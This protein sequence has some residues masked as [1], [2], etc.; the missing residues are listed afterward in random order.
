MRRVVA[1]ALALGTCGAVASHAQSRRLLTVDDLFNLRE[2]RDPQRSPDGQWVAYTVTRAIRD[3]DKNDTDVWMVSWDGTQ[4]I[5]VTST[6]E[7]ESRPRWSPDGKYLSFV[8]S[9]QG[10]KHAQVW[11]LNRAG[12]EAVKL[13]DVKGGVSDYAWSPDSGRLVLVVEDPDPA[14]PPEDKEPAKADP[15]KTPKPIVIDRY[16]FKADVDGYLRGERSH[17]YL[18]D[19]ASK[20]ADALTPGAF[21]EESPAWSP[22]GKR[23]A[24]IRRHG[25]GDVD[26]APN[27]DLFVVEARAGAQPARLTTTTAEETGRV[28]WS[29][30]GSSIAY[31]L[32]DE[33]KYSAYDQHRLAVIPAA[34]GTPKTLTDALD[35]PVTVPIW[36]A[37][38]RSITFVVI[39]DR[40]ERVARVA[41]AGGPVQAIVSGPRV[42]TSISSAADGGL[43]ALVSSATEVPEVYALENGKLRR[44]THQNDEWTNGVL[45]RH[46]RALQLDESATAPRFTA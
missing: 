19:V 13:T 12:G 20:K 38:G 24:F 9:R 22:D 1:L 33:P 31:L 14:D 29:P 7:S 37:D 2:V 6:P 40:S 16:Y 35:R 30:D 46:D 11:L 26:K 25:E 8:S 36:S 23:I 32:G 4:Q 45:V 18:F 34:G 41:A 5:Q 42:V 17:L 15:P 28:A 43:A 10:A 27:R 3:T 39:D 21:D 44:L